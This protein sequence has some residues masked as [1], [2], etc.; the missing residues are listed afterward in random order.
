MNFNKHNGLESALR[1][2]DGLA[3]CPCG[4]PIDKLTITDAGQGAKFANAA[5]NCCGEWMVEFRTN[6]EP[7]DSDKCI[8]LAVAA[9][10]NAPRAANS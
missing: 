4:R 10:N 5:G 7:F 9:W 6:Y 1:L 8:E 2:S 3:A